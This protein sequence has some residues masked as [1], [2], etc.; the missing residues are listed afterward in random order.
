[1]TANL[2]KEITK[3]NSPSESTVMELASRAAQGDDSA[4]MKLFETHR[5][6]LRRVVASRMKSGLTARF[7]TSDV[8]QETF[9]SA[10]QK[11]P[12]YIATQRVPFF[13]WLKNIAWERLID[14][15]R[16]H[17]G[18]ARRSIYRESRMYPGG[19]TQSAFQ[20]TAPDDSPSE[21]LI[22][23]ERQSFLLECLH[24][25]GEH[26]F[27]ILKMRYEDCLSVKVIAEKL[28]L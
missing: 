8:I 12:Q 19:E 17:V 9:V 1:M 7:D 5:D 24:R 6:P 27:Q 21:Q 26:E 14:F 11:L 2:E 4:T 15:N 18:S 13:F 16:R 3:E 25:L 20:F 23:A 28:N 10:T 22:Q